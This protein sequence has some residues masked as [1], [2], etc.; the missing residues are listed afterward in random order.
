MQKAGKGKTFEVEIERKVNLSKGIDEM[1]KQYLALPE[2]WN[3]N[4]MSILV[5]VA[6]VYIILFT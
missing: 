2:A 3:H 1:H 6:L 5:P 4:M